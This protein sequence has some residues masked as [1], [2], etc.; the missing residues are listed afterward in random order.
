MP[1]APCRPIEWL[2]GTEAEAGAAEASRRLMALCGYWVDQKGSAY[3]LMPGSAHSL[4][5]YTARPSGRHR[6]TAHLI[7][8]ALHGGTTRVVWGANRYS[9]TAGG[10]DA[11]T[12][13]GRGEKDYF[14]WV[15]AA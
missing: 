3:H 6:Y 4:H 2:G 5:V 9:L 1:P 14:D 8:L 12:W 15:R 11:I 10:L 7:R 13:K